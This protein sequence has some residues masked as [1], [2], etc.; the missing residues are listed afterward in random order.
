MQEISMKWVVS[1]GLYG[2]L[3]QK[4]GLLINTAVGA[5]TPTLNFNALKGTACNIKYWLKSV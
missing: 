3:P 4:T 5:S 2:V 1:N